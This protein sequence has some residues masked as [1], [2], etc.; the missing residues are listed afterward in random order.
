MSNKTLIKNATI[1]NEGNS[2]I[3][4]ILIEGSIISKIDKEINISSSV[5][6]INAEDLTLIPGM[7]DDQVHFREPGLT[8]KGDIFTESRAAVAGGVTSFIEM[9]NTIPNTINDSALYQK[10][11]IAESN[12]FANFSFMFGGTNNNVDDIINVNESDIAGIKLFLGSST[13]NMLVDNNNI[14][15]EI[16]KK[17]PMLIAVHCEDEKIIQKNILDAKDRFGNKRRKS[18][19][20]LVHKQEFRLLH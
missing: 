4:D 15:E 6:I 17:S 11:G 13:G 3:S 19:R 10:I 18:G 14:L 20:R 7:I 8:H 9:P 5:N 12:S 2:T 1:V 16:F